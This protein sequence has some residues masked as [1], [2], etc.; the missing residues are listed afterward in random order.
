MEPWRENKCELLG[1]GSQNFFF[2]T[3]WSSLRE[4]LFSLSVIS[5]FYIGSFA[6]SDRISV[7]A[8]P[9]RPPLPLST[10]IVSRDFLYPCLMFSH[11]AFPFCLCSRLKLPTRTVKIESKVEPNPGCKMQQKERTTTTKGRLF[12]PELRWCKRYESLVRKTEAER[13]TLTIENKI[14]RK[15]AEHKQNGLDRKQLKM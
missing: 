3:L 4:W 6:Y 13:T 8:E 9:R 2:P 12:V 5:M 14:K 1:C 11:K 10:F 7:L 15:D